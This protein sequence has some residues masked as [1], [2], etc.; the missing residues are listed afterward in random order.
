MVR[1]ESG[2]KSVSSAAGW[3]SESL[4]AHRLTSRQAA[5]RMLVVLV[6]L[7]CYE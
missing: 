5:A 6:A 2:L 7:R 3:Q 1:D 4:P